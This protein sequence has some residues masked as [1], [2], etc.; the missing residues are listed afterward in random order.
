MEG[1][2]ILAVILIIFFIGIISLIC[3]MVFNIEETIVFTHK[4]A[5]QENFAK[6]I[7]DNY[8]D[9]DDKAIGF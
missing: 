4:R 5:K 3:D 2:Y 1:Y 7:A 9:D 6:F 8:Y